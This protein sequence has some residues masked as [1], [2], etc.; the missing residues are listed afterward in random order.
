MAQILVVD[1]EPAICWGLKRL[2]EDLGCQVTTCGSAEAAIETARRVG[3]DVIVLDDRLP[4]MTGLEAIATLQEVAGE[5]PILLITAHGDLPTAVEAMQQNVFEYLVKPFGVE[6]MRQALQRALQSVREDPVPAA[7]SPAATG[8]LV[9]QSVAMREIYR[10]VAMVAGS[11]VSVLLTGESGVGK[12]L[13]ARAIHQYSQRTGKPLV[14]VNA[15]A[16]N[17]ALVESELFGHVRGAFTGAV[18]TQHGLLARAAGGTLFLDEVADIPLPIQ[19]KLLRALEQQEILPVGGQH[20]M[21]SDFRLITATHKGLANLVQQGHFRHD[22]YFRLSGYEIKIP[23]LRERLDDLLPLTQYFLQELAK[24]SQREFYL[25]ERA[26]CELRCRHWPG[27]VR[28]LR[29]V[30]EHAVVVARQGPIELEHL[31][32]PSSAIEPAQQRATENRASRLASA[33]GHWALEQ[34]ESGDDCQRLREQLLEI[35]EPPLLEASYRKFQKQYVAASR[36]LGM[37]RTTLRKKLADYGI[38]NP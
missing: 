38:N 5:V 7:T 34:L 1:D 32:P 10:Q 27:N 20:P 16:L 19:V 25:T 22:L 18:E 2:G 28:E 35:V 23:P 36:A 37:H 3:P 15:A 29:R 9:G 21:R 17:P 13:V 26:I 33:A 31:P 4:G 8:G 6:P 14:V 30:L 12:E 11:D 24:S